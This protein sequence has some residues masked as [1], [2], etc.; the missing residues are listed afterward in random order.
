MKTVINYKK[1]D[2]DDITKANA[3]YHNLVARNYEKSL[4]TT[5]AF[6]KFGQSRI[7]EIVR[8]LRKKT[9]GD[10]FLD[11]GCGTGNVLKFA[12]PYFKNAIG[13]DVSIEMLKTAKKRE[14]SGLLA[15]CYKVP[16]KSNTFDVIACSSLLHHLYDP[17]QFLLEAYRILKRGG[18]LYTDWDPNRKS[19]I[20][21]Y[22]SRIYLF[23]LSLV[24]Y[25]FVFLKRKPDTLKELS[26]VG[27]LAEYHW[28]F[29]KKGLCPYEL[30][31]ALL[32]MGFREVKI[33]F[34]SNCKSI[35]YPK[36][37][38]FMW[39]AEIWIKALLT[40]NFKYEDLAKYFIIL[41]RK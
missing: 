23:L 8:F 5:G 40:L 34:H 38:P 30:K 4:S 19:T 21:H 29:T 11:V 36:K 14:L 1:P 33:I 20:I 10:F 37:I 9:K 2:R 27:K 25:F 31:K 13:I 18:Y 16:F 12:T 24:K 6:E 15:D 28:E 39:R 22:Q 26:S 41:A 35:F 3:I 17:N 32:N 7:K